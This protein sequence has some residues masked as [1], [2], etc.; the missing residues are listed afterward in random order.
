MA[1]EGVVVEG[2]LGIKRKQAAVFATD[3]RIDFHQRS[4]GLRE[5]LVEA[6]HKLHRGIDLRRLQPQRK[7]E[8]AR[9]KRLEP[10]AGV[11]VF[12]ANGIRI[13]GCDL[14]RSPCLPQPMP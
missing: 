9:L 11:D 7:R 6:S 8:L 4:V 10:H 13:F 3:E 12:L 5:R 2:H 1:E 14:L